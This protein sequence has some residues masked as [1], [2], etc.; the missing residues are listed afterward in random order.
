L[1]VTITVFDGADSIGGN[2]IH[3]DF[4]GHGLFFD[5]GQNYKKMGDFYQDFLQPRSSRGL[6][7]FIE[8]GLLPK[9]AHYR[10][11]ACPSDLD[12][13]GARDLRVD[14]LFISHAHMDHIGHAGFL[15]MN[16]PFVATPMSAAIMKAMKDCGQKGVESDSVY[17]SVRK[18][19]EGEGRVICSPRT[20][21][22]YPGRDFVLTDG[23][24][25]ELEDFWRRSTT[26]R[27]IEAGEFLEKD[28]L[29]FEYRSFEVDHSIYGATAYGVSTSSGWII[30]TGDLRAHG[31]NRQKTWDFV[32]DAKGLEPELL[33]IEG[34]R[35]TRSEE[36]ANLSE[37]TVKQTCLEAVR[38]EPKLVVADFGPRNFER[39]D[40][41]MEIAE[42]T[43]RRLV[44]TKKDAYYLQSI[45]S[46]DGVDRMRG[47]SV[48]GALKSTESGAEEAACDCLRAIIL[49]P[50][51]IAQEPE[52]YIACFSFYDMANLLDIKHRGG[53]YVYSSSEAYSEEQVID[54]R[55]LANWL[56][57]FDLRIK[58][59]EMSGPDGIQQPVFQRGYHASGHVC[60]E[61]LLHIID[62]ISPNKVMPVHTE[63]TRP[64]SRA[65]CMVVLPRPGIP[66]PI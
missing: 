48:Y 38:S 31:R 32:R 58:G 23:A 34:T 4:D 55:R 54:F 35:T 18:R 8:M 13:E 40:T 6:H 16:I 63:D 44:V 7:D 21:D 64:F 45:Q 49:D 33:I 25:T 27:E 30:Y 41:F 62:D 1:A 11:D 53:T 2:K 57:L 52:R 47:V 28:F 43:D 12:L 66:V 46:V 3:M 60:T 37:E 56:A 9:I 20:K 24:S 51:D 61:D 15:S 10:Q 39:L 26:K 22:P 19:M 50:K 17:G 29:D 42:E 59:F 65:G 5:F 14:A 36:G